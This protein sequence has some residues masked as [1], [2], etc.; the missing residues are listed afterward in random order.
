MF[1]R[2]EEPPGYSLPPDGVPPGVR[3]LVISAI[4]GAR[5]VDEIDWAGRVLSEWMRLYPDDHE[6]AFYGHQLAR[7]AGAH[8]A[9]ERERRYEATIKRWSESW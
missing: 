7:L 8:E 9:I 3:K 2:D 5:D 4:L 6:V 1:A